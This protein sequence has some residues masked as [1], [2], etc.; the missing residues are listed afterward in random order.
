MKIQWLGHSCFLVETAEGSAVLD[1]YAPGSVPGLALPPLTADLVLCSH[2]HRDHGY[3]QGVALSG[4]TPVLQ[5]KKIET[6]HDERGGALR[7]PNTVHIL[8]AEGL[9]LVHLGDLGHMLTPE[10]LAALGKVDVLLIPVGGHYTIG[11]D[12]AA[13]LTQA[14]AP[15]IA[16]PMHYRGQGFGYDVIGPVEPYLRHFARVERL[17]GPVLRPEELE[18]PAVAVLRC[19]VRL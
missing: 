2:G 14:I 4:K 11:P 17:E 16:V 6:W 7:G 3:A 10:Q 8:E 18:T 9:R 19:P 1:P 5:V 12:V 15:G 13:A